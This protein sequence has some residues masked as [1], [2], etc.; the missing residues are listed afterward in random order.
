MTQQLVDP[1]TFTNRLKQIMEE[2]HMQQKDLAAKSG[3][4]L[5]TIKQYTA[6]YG[7]TPGKKNLSILANALGVSEDWLTGR[8]SFQ[9]KDEEDYVNRMNNLYRRHKK[10]FDSSKRF[11]LYLQALEL[12]GYDITPIISEA[13][14]PE[15]TLKR[16]LF[17]IDEFI[18]MK[19]N[20]YLNRKESEDNGTDNQIQ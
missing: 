16:I 2:K 7:R 20:M 9:T 11:N 1:L 4:S 3:L 15:S 17:D 8:S 12:L 14:D 6:Q 10:A 13:A 5:A 19:G 18:D